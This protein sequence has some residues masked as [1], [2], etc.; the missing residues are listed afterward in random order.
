MNTVPMKN[1]HQTAAPWVWHL[2]ASEAATL[3]PERAPRWLHVE[4]GCVW[5][6]ARHAGPA[7]PDLWLGAGDSL[8]MPAG[9]AWVLQAWPQAQLSVLAP[10]TLQ[11]AARA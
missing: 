10:P 11:P 5:V 9:S 3:M 1:M 4:G 7:S 2:G 8:E 6:T